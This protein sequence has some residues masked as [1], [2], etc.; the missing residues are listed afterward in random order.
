[1]LR[2]IA[3]G[4]GGFLKNEGVTPDGGVAA[5]L[6]T[7][8]HR[9]PVPLC[10]RLPNGLGTVDMSHSPD[11]EKGQPED[12]YEVGYGKPPIGLVDL[13]TAGPTGR[14]GQEPGDTLPKGPVMSAR[15]A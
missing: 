2:A 3:N 8:C 4:S 15:Q 5:E 12:C 9:A 13:H 6:L 7:C 10:A 1:V 11:E 14:V